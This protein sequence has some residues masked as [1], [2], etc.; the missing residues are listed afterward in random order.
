MEGEKKKRKLRLFYLLDILCKKTDD[1]HG[2]TALE[3][4]DM[5]KGYGVN[6]D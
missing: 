3:I 6:I 5:L 4:C 1:E 2:L